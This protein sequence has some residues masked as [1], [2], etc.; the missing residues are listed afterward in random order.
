MIVWKCIILKTVNKCKVYFSAVN[1]IIS[2]LFYEGDLLIHVHVIHFMKR[3]NLYKINIVLDDRTIWYIFFIEKLLIKAKKIQFIVIEL[4]KPVRT[5]YNVHVAC[6]D[7]MEVTRCLLVDSKCYLVVTCTRWRSRSYE[8]AYSSYEMQYTSLG[9]RL[10]TGIYY[11]FS[12]DILKGLVHDFVK[13]VH[14]LF[15]PQTLY[16]GSLKPFLNRTTII[17]LI[18]HGIELCTAFEERENKQKN[19]IL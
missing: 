5:T 6:F 1:E 11:K 4:R 14:N 10:I 3:Y 17:K 16:V 19:A 12:Q 15:L 13:F 7:D 8:I 9:Y 18:V 2:I